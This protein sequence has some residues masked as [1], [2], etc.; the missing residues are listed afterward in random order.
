MPIHCQRGLILLWWLRLFQLLANVGKL[1]VALISELRTC[2]TAKSR[3]EDFQVAL[4][5]MLLLWVHPWSFLFQYQLYPVLAGPF[6]DLPHC[7]R[8]REVKDQVLGFR[9]HVLLWPS[10]ACEAAA[11]SQFG[12]G[13][14][15]PPRLFFRL[16]HFI[17]WRWWLELPA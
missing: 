10:S 5:A 4:G 17:F 3:L 16:K 14:G 12:R 2:C 15:L 8:W 6:R 7:L 1:H 13:L 9:L 11:L